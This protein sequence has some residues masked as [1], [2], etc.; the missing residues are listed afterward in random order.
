M[1]SPVFLEGEQVTLHRIEAGVVAPDGASR[2]VLEKPN[3]DRRASAAVP[4]RGPTGSGDRAGCGEIYTPWPPR[5]RMEIEMRFFA[6]FREAAGQKTVEDEFE[7][8]TTVGEILRS[9]EE[10]YPE[11]EIFDEDGQ[12]R[13][14][15]TIM[16]NGR[17]ISY[18]DK[19]ETVMEDGDVLSVFPPVAG[20]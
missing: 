16:K 7:G 2:R 10:E 9:L 19:L 15:L 18:I 1:A 12:L 20:G 11:M 17:N 5:V 4:R 6:N 8:G 13:D 14:Y 3:S